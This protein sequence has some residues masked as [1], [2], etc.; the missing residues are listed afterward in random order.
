GTGHWCHWPFARNQRLAAGNH[1][2]YGVVAYRH[3]VV[4]TS[5]KALPPAC[6]P[7]AAVGRA[8]DPLGGLLALPA[9]R[10]PRG[11]N[12]QWPA[13]LW[14]GVYG[15]SSGAECPIDAGKRP[16]YGHVR[17]GYLACYVFGG[18]NKQLC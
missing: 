13:A 1:P 6:P 12:A 18:P 14:H 4:F 17:V 7:A 15:V 16:V 10:T 3:G 9:G 2:V 8:V 11:G 5:W